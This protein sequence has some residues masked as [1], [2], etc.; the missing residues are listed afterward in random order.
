MK[1]LILEP[2]NIT[3]QILL[4][5]EKNIY[6]FSGQSRPENVKEFYDPILNWLEEFNTEISMDNLSY[7]LTFIF[8]YEYYN[9]A[10]SK[11]I[12]EIAK[13]LK[14]I[15]DTGVQMEVVWY[16]DEGDDDMRD[17]GTELSKIVKLP[18]TLMEKLE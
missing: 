8:D 9:T 3:P 2:S 18:F 10:S 17:A 1:K 6:K 7:N 4:D 12:L 14:L 16:Y 5:P 11:C 15:K 13:R